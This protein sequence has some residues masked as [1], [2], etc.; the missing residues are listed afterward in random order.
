VT[1]RERI[2]T[3]TRAKLHEGVVTASEYVDKSTDLLA[4]RLVRI[5]HRV[6]LAQARTNFLTTLGVEAP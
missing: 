1:L 3:E 2:E 5:Q 6:E 4:A